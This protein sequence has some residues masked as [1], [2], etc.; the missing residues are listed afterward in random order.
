[1]RDEMLLSV[2]YR[3]SP[4]SVDDSL[5]DSALTADNILSGKKYYL[6]ETPLIIS[7][8]IQILKIIT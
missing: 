2:T 1:M 7:R 4:S 3:S 8:W 6:G 5:R